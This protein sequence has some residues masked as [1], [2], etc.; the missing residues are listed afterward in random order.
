MSLKSV[1][2]VVCRK[3]FRFLFNE[4]EEVEEVPPKGFFAGLFERMSPKRE[5][6]QTEFPYND[7]RGLR[8]LE[9]VLQKTNVINKP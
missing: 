9:S 8:A 5:R 6:V 2:V 4:A 3:A 1:C 7:M